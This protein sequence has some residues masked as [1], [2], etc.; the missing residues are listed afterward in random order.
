MGKK[1]DKFADWILTYGWAI[2][3]ILV[4]IGF[5]IYIY[6]EKF[7]P[8]KFNPETDICL[9]DCRNLSYYETQEEWENFNKYCM[10][11]GISPTDVGCVK[12]RPKNKCELDPEAEGCICDEYDLNNIKLINVYDGRLMGCINRSNLTKDEI[13]EVFP[14]KW[15]VENNESGKYIEMYLDI[16]F[17]CIKSHLPVCKEVCE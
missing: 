11:K 8:D 12:W 1:F 10:G 15:K 5:L 3:V 14:Q 17:S 2:L 4:G 6:S 9:M 16:K 7:N 13:E